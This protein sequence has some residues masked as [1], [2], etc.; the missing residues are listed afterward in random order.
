MLYLT[1][2]LSMK[3]AR[4]MFWIILFSPLLV[5]VPIVFY[6]DKK[7]GAG[8]PKLNSDNHRMDQD[9][10]RTDHSFIFPGGDGPPD[11]Q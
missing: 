2:D 11:T 6:L 8:D 7:K 4:K 1:I 10:A 3:G 9:L 5:L